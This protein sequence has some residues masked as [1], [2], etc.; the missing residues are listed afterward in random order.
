VTTTMMLLLDKIGDAG[1]RSN[2]HLNEGLWQVV[3]AL[4][5][6][7]RFISQYKW[8]MLDDTMSAWLEQTRP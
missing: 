4:G 1:Q 2:A 8:T 7:Q 6:A 3:A 5:F